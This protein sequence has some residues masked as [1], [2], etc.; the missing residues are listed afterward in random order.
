MWWRTCVVLVC[1]TAVLADEEWRQV[2][3]AQGPVRGQKH[4][5]GHLY[6]FYNIPYAT[7]PKG[8]DKFKAPLPP[9]VRTEP[10]DATEKRVI[11]PQNKIVA[12]MQGYE[13]MT[14]DCLVANIFV[15]DTNERNLPV[16][17][18]VHGGAFIIGFGDSA[19]GT[20]LMKS[21]DF[22]M[23]TFNYRLGIHGFLCL[24]TED[25]PGNAGMKDQVA[26]LRWVKDNIA[27]F[28][29]N[30]NDVTLGGCS[31][32][33]ASVDLLL[34]S[35]SAKGLFHHVIPESGGNLAVF[36][37]QRDPVQIAKTHAKNLNFTNVDDIYALEQFYK[38]ASME[39]LTADI[40]FDRTDSTF[41][42]SPCV[43]R[44]TGDGAFLTESPL[45]VL[46]NG[47]YDKLP[48]LYGFANMEGRFREPFFEIWKDKMN[49]NFSQFLPADLIF[50]TEEKREEVANKVK[51][52]YFKDQSVSNDTILGYIDFFSDVLFTHSMLW[53][54]KLQAE[55][56]NNQIYLYEYSF[57]DENVPV[58]A[59]T[60]V[61]GA[62]HCA[63]SGAVMDGGDE[64]KDTLEFQNM[65]KIIR[66]MWH[67]FIIAGKPVPEGSLLPNW[68][69]AG[70][71]RAPYMS[72]GV[73]V[74]QKG[75]F[76]EARTQ[77]W[78]EI[79]EQ[80]YLDSVPPPTPEV[81]TDSAHSDI[82]LS[83]NLIIFIVTLW[84]T[85]VF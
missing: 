62:T 35:K 20:Q 32:G 2:N 12:I 52:F 15:P 57:V 58:V 81:V 71:N 16:L 82:L 48:M 83:F 28:G 53:A 5:S 68:A 31:A 74:E 54:A 45:T 75:V 41:M 44:D 34:L 14:E 38:S 24:G 42:F 69:P 36:S 40:F 26:L 10:L 59:H 29:G 76:L 9:A 30:P 66:E 51:S 21:K 85:K 39:L 77:L 37:M 64:T 79:Y 70:P 6:A 84:L 1:V 4:P 72:L 8:A 23:V 19:R 25:V 46:K 49:T 73:K 60:D 65:R 17:V 78:A 18:Y 43:E 7:A 27:N 67:N 13:E 33:S 11:C 80:H 47:E 61:R 22:I 55:A 63:Q 50:E 3:T 56:G